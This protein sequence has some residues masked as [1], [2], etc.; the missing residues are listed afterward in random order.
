M[1]KD[2]ALPHDYFFNEKKRSVAT[3]LFFN[4]KKRSVATRIFFNEK[5]RSV[6]TRQ[7]SMN[8]NA[9]LP[10]DIFFNEKKTQ[11]CHTAIFQRKKDAALP[12]ENFRALRRNRSKSR[13][14]PN[15]ASRVLVKSLQPDA[16]RQIFRGK[17]SREY[18]IRVLYVRKYS[19]RFKIIQKPDDD[20]VQG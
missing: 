19:K 8:R 1:K 7:F 2:A 15:M 12:H 18:Y 10:H 6:A 17:K 4:E 5:K 11:R 13:H 3:R 16:P 14:P 9:A 20:P